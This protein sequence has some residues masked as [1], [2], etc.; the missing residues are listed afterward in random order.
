MYV[1]FLSQ[2]SD[3][4]YPDVTCMFC[5]VNVP[6]STFKSHKEKCQDPKNE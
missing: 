4:G 6:F 1:Y 3:D 5:G 2:D